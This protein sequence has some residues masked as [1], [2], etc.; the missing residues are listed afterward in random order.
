MR[1]PMKRRTFTPTEA[2]RT[3]PLVRRIVAD[4]LDT[5][6]RLRELAEAGPPA[7]ETEEFR[8]GRAELRRLTD[9]LA[10]LGCEYKDWSFDAGLVDF[11]ARIDGEPVLL[12]WR[13]DEDQVS[14]FH[15]ADAGFA[16]RE[17]IP[18]ELLVE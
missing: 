3:L 8:A 17:R 1:A 6:R 16:G 9:E 5:G 12:C 4:I 7:E 14:W 2:N 15:T 10:E 13:S 11:P 18:A